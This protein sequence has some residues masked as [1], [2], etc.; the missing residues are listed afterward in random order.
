MIKQ[1]YV[2]R[3]GKFVKTRSIFVSPSFMPKPTEAEAAQVTAALQEAIV[4]AE[5]VVRRMDTTHHLLQDCI[6]EV[7]EATEIVSA[8][9]QRAQLRSEADLT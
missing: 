2:R 5:R 7:R 6:R 1:W 4:S 3:S 8:S 9:N